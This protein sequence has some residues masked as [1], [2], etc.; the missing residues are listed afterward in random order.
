[1]KNA[2]FLLKP[3]CLTAVLLLLLATGGMTSAAETPHTSVQ[4]VGQ[5]AEAVATPATA[6][7]TPNPS[8][9]VIA[10]ESAPAAPA[11]Q[12]ARNVSDPVPQGNLEFYRTQTQLQNELQLLELQSK[13]AD[14]KKK[15]AEASTDQTVA[16]PSVIVAPPASMTPQ[17]GAPSTPARGGA[18]S[19]SLPMADMN[20]AP[21]PLRVASVL[22]INGRFTAQLVDHGVDCTVTVGTVLSDGWHVSQIGPSTVVLVR[23][24]ARRILHVSE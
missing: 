21:Q 15:I 13:I 22:G 24:R 18:S 4:L 11:G 20:P 1:M 3:R 17:S 2:N 23:G 7:T 9:G 14:Y 16:A 5:T 8:H 10:T 19:I 12:V 6:S